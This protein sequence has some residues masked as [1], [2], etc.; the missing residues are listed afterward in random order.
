M[1]FVRVKGIVANPIKRDLRTEIEFIADT[2]AIYTVI[3]RWVANKL[4]LEEVS[5]RRFKIASG[6]IAEYPVSEA[7]IMIE[8]RG[9]TSLVVI[10]T[11]NMP[12]LLGVTT[13]ELLGL[14]V[15]PV[16]GRLKPLELLILKLC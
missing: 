9:V 8:D 10:G 14:Q 5:K 1:G 3:P 7:Y 16:T 13:L 6:E 11:E 2:G 12:T 15:D 4:G